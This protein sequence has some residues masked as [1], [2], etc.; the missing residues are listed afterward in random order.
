M[1]Y[2]SIELGYTPVVADTD[3]VDP[4]GEWDEIVGLTQAATTSYLDRIKD[5]LS[6]L[7]AH[8]SFVS[9]SHI[10]HMYVLGRSHLLYCHGRVQNM[11]AGLCSSPNEKHI[12]SYR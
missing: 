2:E 1:C 12:N 4:L 11:A 5:L 9:W 10:A 8:F 3:L 7:I 6:M